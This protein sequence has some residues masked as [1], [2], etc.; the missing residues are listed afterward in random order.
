MNVLEQ[1]ICEQQQ[2]IV[3]EA[4][5]IISMTEKHLVTNAHRLNIAIIDSELNP[6]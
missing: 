2:A 5:N 6:Q 1:K 4:E 3:E